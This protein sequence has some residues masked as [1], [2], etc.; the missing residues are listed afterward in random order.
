MYDLFARFHT[1]LRF[2]SDDTTPIQYMGGSTSLGLTPGSN[3]LITH[4][5]EV[6]GFEN[7]EASFETE[8][9]DNGKQLRVYFKSGV[10]YLSYNSMYRQQIVLMNGR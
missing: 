1:A 7:P 4:D 9:A 8:M 10:M 2:L 6:M 5:E 3:S